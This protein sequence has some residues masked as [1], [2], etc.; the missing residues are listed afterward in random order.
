[1]NN[2]HRVSILNSL[3]H[4]HSFFSRTYPPTK[5]TMLLLGAPAGCKVGLFHRLVIILPKW[6]ACA[7][8]MFVDLC[9]FWNL[10]PGAVFQV[11]K[12]KSHKNWDHERVKKLQTSKTRPELEAAT[13]NWCLKYFPTTVWKRAPTQIR[14]ARRKGSGTLQPNQAYTNFPDQGLG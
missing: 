14:S 3:H 9:D 10:R 5:K 2:Q 8:P 1:M 12:K 11:G 7:K 6:I 4:W 13:A